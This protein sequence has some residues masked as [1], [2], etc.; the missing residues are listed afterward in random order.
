[1]KITQSLF[2]SGITVLFY[3]FS[4]CSGKTLGNDELILGTSSISVNVQDNSGNLLQGFKISTQPVTRNI[5]TDST[6]YA[7][8]ENIPKGA[9]EVFV[10]KTDFSDFSKSVTIDEGE[11]L[12]LSFTYLQKVN[13][14]IHDDEG[15]L[16]PNATIWTTPLTFS[17][18]TDST[19][20]ALFNNMPQRPLDFT[21]KRENYPS[22]ILHVPTL[23]SNLDLVVPS[24]VPK[25]SI[26]SPLN[27]SL[28]LIKD[29]IRFNGEGYDIEDGELPDSSM[30]WYSDRDGRLGYGKTLIVPYLTSGNHIITLQGID[31]DDKESE[32]LILISV[33]DD[34]HT[35]YFPVPS[36]ENWSYRYLD[37]DFYITNNDGSV[38]YWSLRDI[39]VKI[40]SH[41]DRITEIYWDI[42]VNNVQTHFC[43]TLTDYLEIDGD[44]L[45]IT[46]TIEQSKEWIGTSSSYFIMDITTLYTP[47]YLFLKNYSNVMAEKN[48]SSTVQSE[49]LWNYV[50]YS[51][52]SKTYTEMTELTTIIQVGDEKS[53]ETDKGIFS[54]VNLTIT[55]NNAVK[56][57][58]LTKGI[59]LVRLEDNTFSPSA[60][61]ILNDASIFRFYEKTTG[62]KVLLHAENSNMPFH[63]NL[64]IDRTNF[65]NMR[66]FQKFLVSMCPR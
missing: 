48:Y 46:K 11:I 12:K 24:A 2:V 36:E 37:S 39:N 9:Y 54:A 47:R 27:N 30:I 16:C 56:K 43:L 1:M 60:V 5:M 66:A 62:K 52:I 21:I 53:V 50:Y 17:N 28:I 3:I 35:S 59:G 45:Y 44:N 40:G 22:E 64:K 8:L 41:L 51:E 18:T 23:F 29:N 14:V 19:G 32:T 7:F 10:K 42:E 6:G 63:P 61:A 4:G 26:I 34:Q 65:E 55:Q 31:S 33:I 25:V 15:R 13:V 57:W 58:S 38:E 20:A 49:T